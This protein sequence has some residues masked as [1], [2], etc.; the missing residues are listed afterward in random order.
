MRYAELLKELETLLNQKR[1]SIE[2]DIKEL[3]WF[4]EEAIREARF[5]DPKLT[6]AI[7]RS[8]ARSYLLGHGVKL[9]NPLGFQMC[10]PAES[11]LMIL[12]VNHASDH[13]EFSSLHQ[14]GVTSFEVFTASLKA[15]PD[16][17]SESSLTRQKGVGGET[18]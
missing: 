6:F 7:L 8:L 14:A 2:A 13:D 4:W 1:Q 16:D 9:R 12:L 17:D 5:G 15:Y 18:D 11:N 10:R 3:A